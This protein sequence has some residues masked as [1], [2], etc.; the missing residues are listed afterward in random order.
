MKCNVGKIE[1]IIR[2]FSGI[3]ILVLGVYYTSYFGYIAIFFLLTG[4]L[5]WCPVNSLF[6]INNCKADE[7]GNP[8]EK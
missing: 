8:L 7:P 2:V 5:R 6:K 4:I 3:I 1:K